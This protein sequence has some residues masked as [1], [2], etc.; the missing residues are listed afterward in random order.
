MYE[1]NSS[2]KLLGKVFSYHSDQAKMYR[3]NVLDRNK[4]HHDV[5]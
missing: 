1:I 3:R 4:M 2:T 5:E